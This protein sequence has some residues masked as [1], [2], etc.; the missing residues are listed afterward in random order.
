MQEIVKKI[1]DDFQK[2]VAEVLDKYNKKLNEATDC[3]IVSKV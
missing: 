2:E 1:E 3:E